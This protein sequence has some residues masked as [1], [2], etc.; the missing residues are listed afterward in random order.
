[1]KKIYQAEDLKPG[2]I[3]LSTS[4]SLFSRLLRWVM[5]SDWRSHSGIYM[6]GEWLIHSKAPAGV[7][8]AKIEDLQTMPHAIYRIRHTTETQQKTICNF[9]LRMLGKRYDYWHVLI[10]GFRILMG[11]IEEY[12]GDMCPNR[13]LC[14]ELISGAYCAAGIPLSRIPDNLLPLHIIQRDDSFLVGGEYN[15]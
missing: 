1:M 10:Y 13:F 6:G 7:Q 9:C 15:E 14:F 2:D 11:H 4:H 12:A 8:W 5:K 3:I